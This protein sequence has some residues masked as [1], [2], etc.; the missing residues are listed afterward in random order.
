MAI[1]VTTLVLSLLCVKVENV[2]T[3]WIL[4]KIKNVVSV[5]ALVDSK[6][7]IVIL[8]LM[9]VPLTFV[10]TKPF[11]SIILGHVTDIVTSL[12]RKFGFLFEIS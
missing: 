8:I 3:I 6:V 12:F 1:V 7:T 4:R 5:T 10:E 9:S 11:A 2:I